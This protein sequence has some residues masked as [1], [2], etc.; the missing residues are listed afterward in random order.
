MAPVYALD[1]FY[2]SITAL[3]TVAYQMLGFAV[4]WTFKFDKVTDFTG[5]K[6]AVA[7][8]FVMVWA[9]RIAG[10]LR[11]APETR[12]FVSN[13]MCA[14]FLLYRVLK[15]GS[16]ARF[17]EIRNSFFKFLA[18]WIGD[19]SFVFFILVLTKRFV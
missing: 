15:V 10:V 18:F 19:T 8:V 13:S 3:V 6:V 17:D 11:K 4:A 9:T 12:T 14:G 7:S 16:D 5:V 2:L 1:R